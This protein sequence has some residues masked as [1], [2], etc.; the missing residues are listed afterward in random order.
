MLSNDGFRHSHRLGRVGLTAAVVVLLA[1]AHGAAPSTADARPVTRADVARMVPLAPE[2]RAARARSSGM[3]DA[4]SKSGVLSLQNPELYGQAGPR[5]D[6]GAAQLAINAGLSVPVDLFGQR[7]TRK[8]AAAAEATAAAA[9]AR[10]STLAPLREGLVLHAEALAAKARAEVFAR[11]L[12]LVEQLV[13]AADRRRKAGEVAE[14]DVALVRLQLSRERAAAAELEGE[15][16]SLAH[17]LAAILALPEGEMADA[18]GPLVPVEG[19]TSSGAPTTA[20][21][22]A[23]AQ[24]QAA[25]ARL[26]REEA[27]GRPTVSLLGN[28]ELDSG[29]HIITGGIGIPLPFYGVN[30]AQVAVARGEA[31]AADL[32]VIGVRRNVSG[33]LASLRARVGA[34][35][36][37][38][39]AIRPAA[40]EAQE[41]V[42]RAQR[43]YAAGESDLPT[44]LLIRREALETELGVVDAELGHALAKLDLLL[45]Q[46]RWSR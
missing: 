41:I 17:R 16:Q 10:Q 13:T 25:R 37:A 38:L 8:D 9:A 43:A 3:S 29:A 15:N 7:A 28:Y 22:A 44:L 1:A 6:S 39:D 12:E 20:V 4:A 31:A 40:A 23:E 36:K 2:A 5:I 14:N 30:D 21:A 45:A 42:A 27:A 26:A 24:R 11:R 19:V 34:T 18:V 35:R 33:Q 46:G 32:E